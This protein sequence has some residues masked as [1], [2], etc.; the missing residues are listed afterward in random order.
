EGITPGA[1]S[2]AFVFD[3]TGSMWDDLKQVI[4][5]SRQILDT[6]RN[7]QEKPLYNYVL[8]PFHDPGKI[9]DF[10]LASRHYPS[11][12]FVIVGPTIVTTDPD[13]FTT[14]LKDLYVQGGGDCPEMNCNDRGHEGYRAYERIAATSSGQVFRINREQVSE[15]VEFIRVSVQAHK[16][17]L[18]STDHDTTT[19][20]EHDWIIPLDPELEELTLSVSGPDRSLS[21]FDP[22]GIEMTEQNGLNSQLDLEKVFIA[23]I[24]EPKPARFSRKPTVN[25]SD[26]EFQP[27]A[28]I[29]TY[30][31]VNATGLALPGRLK[32]MK[33]LDIAGRI[34]RT[35]RL[36]TPPDPNQPYLYTVEPFMTP[37]VPFYIAVE[38]ITDGGYNFIRTTKNAIINV[39]PAFFIHIKLMN[40]LKKILERPPVITTGGN[41]TVV[42]GSS[43]ILT[44]HVVSNVQFSI[45]WSRIDG[46]HLD[47]N[48]I[49]KHRNGS[50]IIQGAAPRDEA[51]YQCTAVNIGG[52]TNAVVGLI[53]Q[54]PPT[55]TIRPSGRSTF[56]EGGRIRIRCKASGL[57]RP[58]LEWLKGSN[59]LLDI[60]KI[61]ISRN[62]N[63][64]EII[65]ANQADGGLYTCQ[66]SNKAG[67][68]QASVEWV[69]TELPV[70]QIPEPEMLVLEG[71]SATLRCL[72]SGVPPPAVLWSRDGNNIVTGRSYEITVRFN[73]SVACTA[74]GYPEPTVTW[75]QVNGG[76]DVIIMGAAD[77]P[78]SNVLTIPEA[79]LDAGGSYVCTAS[80]SFGSTTGTTRIT[81][82]GTA[83]PEVDIGNTSPHVIIGQSIV[84]PCLIISGNPAPIR[85]WKRRRVVFNP[86][87]R[88]YINEAGSI[89]I[90]RAERGDAG[91]YICHA[92]NVVGHEEDRLDL[93]IWVLPRITT[94][95]LVYNTV[96]HIP[97]SMQCVATGN[98]L[99][100]I[101]WRKD[102]DPRSL[103]QLSGY[104]VSGDGTLTILDPNHDDEGRYSCMASNP[105]GVDSIDVIL[106][107]YLRPQSNDSIHEYIVT[108]GHSVT[109]VCDV[110]GSDPP[111]PHTSVLEHQ[112]NFTNLSCS[113]PGSYKCVATNIA[114]SAENN[115]RLT[116]QVPPSIRRGPSLIKVLKSETA[117]LQCHAT[118]LPTPTITWSREDVLIDELGGR[119]SVLIT[120]IELGRLSLPCNASGDPKPTIRWY[121]NGAELTGADPNVDIDTDG[122]LTLY[123]VTADNNGEY[124][125]EAENERGIIRKVTKVLVH[126]RPDIKGGGGI[127]RITVLEGENVDL[128]CEADAVPP[129]IITWYA[130]DDQI[131]EEHRHIE[132][133]NQGQIF[134]ITSAQVSDTGL[135]KCTA[136]NKVGETH[137]VPFFIRLDVYV[138][139]AIRDNDAVSVQ[140][141]IVDDS[142]DMHCYADGIPF[143]VIRWYTGVNEV[144]PDDER[145]QFVNRNQTLRINSALVSD[146]GSYKCIAINVAGDASKDFDLDVH[147]PP[148]IEGEES[149]NVTVTLGGAVTLTCDVSGDPPPTIVWFMF[150]QP[151]LE[152][153]RISIGN[154]GQ[155]LEISNVEVA[156]ATRYSCVAN[157]IVGRANKLVTLIVHVPATIIE[158]VENMVEHVVVEGNRA[159]L[160]CVATGIPLPRVTWLKDGR[161]K[162]SDQHWEI[163]DV[164]IK[165]RLHILSAQLSHVGNYWCEATNVA[166]KSRKDYRL[167]VIVPPT[168]RGS[169]D[170]TKV[171]VVLNNDITMECNVEGIPT[172]TIEWRK[173]GQL[174]STLRSGEYDISAGGSRLTVSNAL[175]SDAGRYQCVADNTAGNATKDF[176]LDVY[177][178]P[179][180][181]DSDIA[182]DL[183]V[184]EGHNISL[185]CDADA[186]PAPTIECI[187]EEG[188]SPSDV[189]THVNSPTLLRCSAYG[190]PSPTIQWLKEGNPFPDIVSRVHILSEGQLLEIDGSQTSDT[191]RY[192][193]F[194]RNRAGEDSKSFDVEV[195]SKSNDR[196]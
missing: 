103:E 134:R 62:G 118:G 80:N 140:T 61:R 21:L 98:P 3:V 89:V 4:A 117:S 88:V 125:C 20:S 109:L 37:D 162:K 59:Y 105:A 70:V 27:V 164:G 44:C 25:W 67:T 147:V 185:T 94:T 121:Y 167:D 127:E 106:E 115:M 108:I 49:R 45:S 190:I 153:D 110:S 96:E 8:I 171:S 113:T 90:T 23:T 31:L 1:S 102:G 48:R 176:L 15:V 6:T 9:E 84:L 40:P 181:Q 182:Q 30:V 87:G 36:G 135:Y 43:V 174:V 146:T 51:A 55:V 159:E 186:I 178:P 77:Q 65:N 193:C 196:F 124:V 150:G 170:V 12:L 73:T 52:E 19:P 188:S 137:K 78:L 71:T 151:V 41:Q 179:S 66:A 47:R 142:V 168:I 69:F 107:I 92:T 11:T 123:V 129:P 155:D 24:T 184:A 128:M 29:P 85:R 120:P 35:I 144:I 180:I 119:F 5:G 16:V 13:E 131:I 148:S 75:H 149:N 57:P 122:T 60:G 17:M 132:F 50:L 33:L 104:E 97:V 191:G 68:D 194:A 154:R 10:R 141:V 95:D 99:P 145:V 173:G 130:G 161:P 56:S 169:G 46:R 116:V 138:P 64:L 133:V 192:T 112:T 83:P 156:D 177:F 101:V 160:A 79:T 93:D 32:R 74:I 18:L 39:I 100:D 76:S 38:G 26:T 139:P 22:D 7:R 82:T 2:L 143:P 195:Q 91:A 81:I 166:G 187:N 152:S 136:V 54:R 53:V 172:P 157:N 126:E 58:K 175:E 111:P 42:P 34:L 183:W 86:T 72:T 158:P 28:T 14:A 165:Q 114:G 189:T 163:G 63:L